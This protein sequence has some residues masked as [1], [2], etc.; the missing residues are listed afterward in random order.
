MITGIKRKGILPMK[1]EIIIDAHDGGTFKAF[2]VYPETDTPVPAMRLA[3]IRG[4]M[5]ASIS[6]T[7]A[8]VRTTEQFPDEPEASTHNSSDIRVSQRR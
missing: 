8:G 1:K 2:A 5:P 7:P 3:A 4:P 6:T